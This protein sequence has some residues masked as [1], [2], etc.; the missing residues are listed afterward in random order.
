MCED[1]VL[2]THLLPRKDFCATLGVI[3]WSR[4]ILSDFG[5]ENFAARN[6]NV[7]AYI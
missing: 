3:G 4:V 1:A 6:L 2:S 5:Y 7:G